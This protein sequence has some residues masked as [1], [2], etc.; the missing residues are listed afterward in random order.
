MSLTVSNGWTINV[1]SILSPFSNVL[2]DGGGTLD[3]SNGGTAYATTVSGLVEVGSGGTVSGSLISAG[4]TQI[5]SSGG[6]ALATGIA[7]GVEQV[8]GGHTTGTTI[9][10][11]NASQIV[12]SGGIAEATNVNGGTQN[13]M[14]GGTALA[15]NLG[16]NGEQ[17]VYSGG[18]AIDTVVSG[19]SVQIVSAGGTAIDTVF[20]GAAIFVG[21]LGIDGGTAILSGAAQGQA[22]VTFGSG[23]GTL[24][25]SGT[26]MPSVTIDGMASAG[27][28]A[29]DLID[30][31]SVAFDPTGSAILDKSNV[32][33]FFEGGQ[34]YALAFDPTQDFSGE[35]F[36]FSA[37]S[38]GGTQIVLAAACYAAGTRIA[39]T[40]GLVPVE[41]LTVGE[42]VRLAEGGTAPVVW[43]GHR[44]VA[45]RRHPRPRDVLP[46]RIAAHA[47]GLD[48]PCRDLW[49]SPDHAVFVDGVLIPV[50]YLL[51]GA[52]L[53]QE[54]AVAT[55]AYWHVEL[56]RHG[57]LLAEGLPAESYLDSGNRAA[58]ANAGTL[59]LAHA[60]FA[61][62][63][64]GNNG[65]APLVTEGA[66]RDRV[67]TRLIAQ[68]LAL[69]WRP[70][71]AGGNA[72]RWAPPRR[73][74]AG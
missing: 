11:Y 44:R 52:T 9:S 37:D 69:G 41:A 63:V 60:D 19:T 47:F 73:A 40:R 53:A 16:Q 57:V 64:W 29:S 74:A 71:D 38:S 35:A 10:N 13:I 58:F 21:G 20:S 48:R 1:T 28:A 33:S 50:R 72:V 18:M 7:W 49:L 27:A 2:V 70:Q 61:R 59:A 39:T 4:G 62:R 6:V 36:W 43:L 46:V 31:P 42:T 65:C 8:V 55:I 56:P 32:L 15:T 3:V 23:G 68:A 25:I 17:I 45:C 5:V 24:E 14:A 51:N 67:Y 54:E 34:S 30:L 66:M 26:V 22:A 12:S